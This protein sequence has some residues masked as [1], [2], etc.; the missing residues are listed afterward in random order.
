MAST[1]SSAEPPTTK[2]ALALFEAVEKKFPHATIGDDKW[3]LVVL[4]ALV[5]VEAD[6]VGTLYTYLINKPQFSTSDSRQALV[7]R[8]REALLE[9]VSIQGICKPLQALFAIVDVEKPED[10]DYSFSRENWKSGPENVSRGEKWLH[11][12]YKHNITG[13]ESKMAAHKDFWFIEQ[14]VIYG[15]YLSDMSIL[16]PVDTQIEMVASFGGTRLNKVPRV[17]DIEHE[18]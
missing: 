9:N 4:S 13:P 8:L 7:R 3:Y 17:A 1:T 12:L 10:R 18:V 2:E 11:T 16:G 14:E 15:L 6:H 5:A